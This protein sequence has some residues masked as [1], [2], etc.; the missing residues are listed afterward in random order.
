V[1]FLRGL[2]H[3][4]VFAALA[5]GLIVT[6]ILT[7]AIAVNDP[8]TQRIDTAYRNIERCRHGR[9]ATVED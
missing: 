9:S 6:L 7:T 2:G 3:G 4:A 5:V 8:T 1:F